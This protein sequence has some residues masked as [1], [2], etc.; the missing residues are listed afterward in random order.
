MRTEAEQTAFL[1]KLDRF[2]AWFGSAMRG[3]PSD[4]VSLRDEMAAARPAPSAA[5]TGKQAMTVQPIQDRDLPEIAAY[6]HRHLNPAIPTATWVAAFRRGWL[7]DPPNHGFKLLA[8]GVLVGTLGAIYSRQ[9]IDGQDLD[10]CNLTSLVVDEAHRARSM[11]LISACLSQKQFRFT[12]FTPTESVAKMLRLFRFRELRAGE[13]VLAHAP[14]PPRLFGIAALE[15]PARLAAALT[16]QDAKLWQ[17]HREIP[18]LRSFAVGRGKAWCVVFWKPSNIKGLP[19]ARILG[20]SDPQLFARWH[21]AIGGHLLLRHGVFGSRIDEHLLCK[22]DA[23][24]V[25]RPVK[26]PR[27]YRGPE[28]ADEKIGFL[29]SELAALPI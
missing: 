6:W 13:R 10:F 28:L 29:Y 7:P 19:A 4:P 22:G 11:D 3:V 14:L 23:L 20:V 15:R 17:D 2:L 25:Y 21:R 5:R 18:W 24:G 9:R 1:D 26:M 12:N 16:G 27:L 8:D